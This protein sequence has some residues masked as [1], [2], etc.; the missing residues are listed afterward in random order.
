MRSRE[1]LRIVFS[2]WTAISTENIV[3]IHCYTVHRWFTCCYSDTKTAHQ[4]VNNNNPEIWEPR[5]PDR[6][7]VNT[8][9]FWQFGLCSPCIWRLKYGI[10]HTATDAP[11]IRMVNKYCMSHACTV[12]SV[13]LRMA[14]LSYKNP[15]KVK[16]PSHP[17]V[18][19]FAHLIT[20]AVYP[21]VS[22]FVKIRCTTSQSSHTWNI[23]CWDFFCKVF[24][25]VRSTGWTAQLIFM[26]DSS[27]DVGR[28]KEVPSGAWSIINFVKGDF[29]FP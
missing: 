6:S 29:S 22:N 21:N 27:S 14:S 28:R 2:R 3:I 19:S 15:A 10:Y 24:I 23:R 4:R 12:C 26:L 9:K 8:N 18:W 11:L 25:F 20:L 5:K 13:V 17:L 7:L 16:P 1:Q